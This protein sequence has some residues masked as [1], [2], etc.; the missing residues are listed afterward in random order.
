VRVLVTRP[1]AQAGGLCRALEGAG[2]TPLPL[3]LLEVV[4]PTDPHPL[5]DALARLAEFDWVALASANAVPPVAERLAPRAWP[6]GPR[7]AV[8]GHATAAAAERAGW[9]VERIAGKS[10]AEGLV[11]LLAEEV[12][13][14]RVLLPQAADARPTLA[15]GLRA[16]GARVTAV[17]AYDKRLPPET[18]ARLRA[19]VACGPLDWATVTSPRVGLHLLAVLQEARVPRPRLVSIGPVTSAALREMGAPPDAEA[20]E[21]SDAA[22]AAAIQ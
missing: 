15:D 8:V 16:T 14:C 9:P 18:T 12:R 7:L 19:L 2:L 20:A 10:R 6:D 21:P 13:G 11:E 17:T 1:A 3:P 22:L 5:D 4:Q